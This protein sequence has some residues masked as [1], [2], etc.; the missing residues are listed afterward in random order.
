MD[1]VV[2]GE[3][4]VLE[5]TKISK[6]ALQK[7][8]Y[9]NPR[10][11]EKGIM[12]LA[13]VKRGRFTPRPR[14]DPRYFGGDIPFIQTAEVIATRDYISN[15]SQTLNEDG[16]KVSKMFPQNTIVMV[17][18]GTY[19]GSVGILEFD[20][21]FTDSLLGIIANR[22][23]LNQKYLFYYMQFYERSIDSLA[24]EVAQRN[25]SIDLFKAFKVRYPP[26]LKLQGELV[27][28]IDHAHLTINRVNSQLTAS[29][30][31][32]KSLINQIF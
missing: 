27:G 26:S 8:I 11:E 21:A 14:N 29:R 12:E 28:K 20:S 24:T 30:A 1:A 22:D 3:R 7:E 16:L 6:L 25:L 5:E 19:V 10:F 15:Y 4:G 31:L 13:S 9:S 23:L 17:I 18:A 2:E 32:Q